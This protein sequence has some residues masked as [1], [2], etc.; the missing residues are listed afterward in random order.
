M[1]NKLSFREFYRRRLPHIQV[2][3]ATYFST[4]RLAGSLPIEAL[5][6]L[7]EENQ[8]INKLPEGQK[9]AAHQ[10]WFTKYDDYLDKAL[11]GD[12]YLKNG[13]IADMVAESMGKSTT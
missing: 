3:G 11:F 2:A 7:S 9:E 12:A 13:Q 10:S 8:K 5:E 4:F 6:K 1:Q